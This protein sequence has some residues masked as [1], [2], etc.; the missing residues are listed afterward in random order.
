MIIPFSVIPPI[1]TVVILRLM[2]LVLAAYLSHWLVSEET[3]QH[4][5]HLLIS[6]ADQERYLSPMDSL[7]LPF[8]ENFTNPF[9]PLFSIAGHCSGSLHL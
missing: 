8:R 6:S 9:V 1:Y 4:Y 3:S 5:L 2:N 7:A